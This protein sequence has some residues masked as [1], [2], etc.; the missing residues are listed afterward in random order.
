MITFVA[1]VFARPARIS[2]FRFS[3][4][5]LSILLNPPVVLSNKKDTPARG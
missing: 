2:S 5:V 4:V 1:G 3:T